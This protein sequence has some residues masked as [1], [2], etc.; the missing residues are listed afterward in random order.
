MDVCQEQLS[1]N[2]AAFQF[3][4][5][6]D[7]I[8]QLRYDE[9]TEAIRFLKLPECGLQCSSEEVA[10]DEIHVGFE[11][12]IVKGNVL[13]NTDI[14]L[15]RILPAQ[16]TAVVFPRFHSQGKCRQFPGPGINLNAVKIVLQNQRWNLTRRKSRFLINSRQQIESIGQHVTGT[17]ARIAD[18]QFFRRHHFEKIGILFCRRNII[19]HGFRK[20]GSGMIQH[21]QPAE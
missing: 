8:G 11:F 3:G 9:R 20:S 7:G 12:L 5:Y 15:G 18:F 4:E 16:K 13:Q 21:P 10:A 6:R 17:A 1:G 14:R 2:I 19:L